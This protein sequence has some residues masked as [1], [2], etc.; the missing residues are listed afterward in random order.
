MSESKSK[1][2][3]FRLSAEIE[4]LAQK[5]AIAAGD[6]NASA[7]CQK[8]VMNALSKIAESDQINRLETSSKTLNANDLLTVVGNLRQLNLD[9]FKVLMKNEDNYKEFLQVAITSEEN[10]E[11]ISQGFSESVVNELN[12]SNESNNAESKSDNFNLQKIGEAIEG[13]AGEEKDLDEFLVFAAE[14]ESEVAE[15]FADEPELITNE[16]DQSPKLAEPLLPE[17]MPSRLP[18]FD[19]ADQ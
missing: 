17:Q 6:K 2:I 4:L 8:L 1:V 3:S 11:L 9:C 19:L 10:W 13:Q 15:V 12:R 16:K 14:L 7:W 18:F 5:A